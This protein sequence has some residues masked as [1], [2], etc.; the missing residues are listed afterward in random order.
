[1]NDPSSVGIVGIGLLGSAIAGRLLAANRLV[2]GYDT[3]AQQL[4]RFEQQGGMVAKDAASVIQNCQTV[5]LSLPSSDVVATVVGQLKSDVQ[6]GQVVIDTTTGDPEQMIAIGQSLAELGAEYV[7]ATVAGSSKQVG[8]GEAAIFVGGA[9]KTVDRV[10]PIL[11]TL[12][13]TFYFMGAVGT[14]SRMKLVHNLVLGLNRAV[15]AEGLMFAKGMG[16]DQGEA[17]RILQQTPAA[18]RVMETKGARM[19]SGDF[20]PQARLSQHLKDVRLILAASNR[21]NCQTPL[22]ELHRQLLET[23]VELGLGEFDN[24]AII[25]VFRESMEPDE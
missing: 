4:T 21:S 25:R 1:M 14:A 3:N 13:D 6:P 23:A 12:T 11:D 16:I 20:E 8:D 19:V 2:Y 9:A 7:E 5:L 10:R 22:S 17:L 24:S 15:L 18:S